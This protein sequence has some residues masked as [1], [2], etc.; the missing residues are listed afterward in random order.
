MKKILFAISLTIFFTATFAQKKELTLAESVSG[1]YRQFYPEHFTGFKWIPGTINFAAIESYQ[2]LVFYDS[3][4]V[5]TKT[6]SVKDLGEHLGTTFPYIAN[7]DF[8]NSEECYVFD[9]KSFY[10]YNWTKESGAKIASSKY[11]FD[12]AEFNI[13]NGQVA[14]TFENNLMLTDAK[15]TKNITDFDDPNI[16]SGQAI[17]RSEFGI[18]NG[19]FWSPK[20]NKIAFYQKDESKVADYPLLDITST[21]GTLKSIKYPMAGQGSEKPAVGIFDVNT[22]KVVYLEFRGE[23]DHYYTNLSWSPDEKFVLV[24]EV[25]RGQNHMQLN[26]YDAE[27]GKYMATLFEEKHDKYVEPEHPAYFLPDNPNKFI[28][29]TEKDGFNNLYLFDISK[30]EENQ[31]T[32]NKWV[33]KDVLELTSKGVYFTGTGPDARNTLLFYVDYKGKQKQITQ[34]NGT[35][36]VVLNLEKGLI[37]DQYS[38]I[39]TPNV[40]RILSLS[41]KEVKRLIT[42]KNPYENITMGTAE[43]GNINAQNDIQ[44]HY[45]LIKP[46]NFDESKK[47]PVLVYVYGGPHAQL[48]TN[49]WLGGASLWMYWMAE[50]GYLVFTVDGRGSANRGR[51]FENVIHR[52]LGKYEIQDQMEGVEFL[53]SQDYVDESRLAVHGWSFGGYMTI[54][55]MLKK[56]GVFN[57]G[58]AGGPVTDWSYYEVMYGERYMDTPEENPDGYQETALR[59]HV[60]NLEG[61]LMMI[62]G[63]VDNVVVMQHSFDLI[64]N[65]INAGKQ[66]DFFPYPMHEHN[67]YGRDRVHLM[68]KVLHYIL[69]NNK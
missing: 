14:H 28:W 29:V 69:E 58:V 43:Y 53:K 36:S 25:N 30:R 55:L 67:V 40:A 22:N 31:L 60:D 32:K 27:T 61:K 51:D 48:V 38:N 24:A 33:V 42:A 47:Y 15:A 41:G 50:Q 12:N 46:S 52:H 7:V 21:P 35:H 3:K 5:K 6:I 19:I 37:F 1:Q 11:N 8:K 66:V 10:V 56:A 2:A 64:K 13:E 18:T 16:V 23:K 65:F 45:R 39:E 59:N 20:S 17:A 4:G 9:G 44:L 57:A 62:H 54:S 34:E 49:S 63:T 68:D 26:Q